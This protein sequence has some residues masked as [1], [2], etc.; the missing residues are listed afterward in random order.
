VANPN[1]LIQDEEERQFSIADARGFRSEEDAFDLLLS[2]RVSAEMRETL[3]GWAKWFR[4]HCARA[5]LPELALDW[6]A[7]R[8]I[9]ERRHVVLHSGGLVSSEYLAKLEF[10]KG[11]AP[12][13][14]SRLVV[15]EAYL[16]NAFDQLDALGTAIGILAWGTWFPDERPQ[17]TSALVNR[18]YELLFLERWSVVEKIAALCRRPGFECV[19]GARHALR[20]NGWFARAE[21]DGYAAI[22][23]EVEMWDASALSLT[24]RLVRLVLLQKLEDALRL[25]PS[26]LAPGSEDG[27]TR[28]ELRE[29]PILRTLRAHPGYSFIADEHEI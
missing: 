7:S 15:D 16:Q 13:L 10:P 26:A 28:G 24:F 20:C 27:L 12:V 5:D 8:E 19:D 6:Q 25:V 3:A 29:W 23:S 4:K 17:S 9:F 18:T 21:R 14:G 22:R 1:A 2:R 11:S